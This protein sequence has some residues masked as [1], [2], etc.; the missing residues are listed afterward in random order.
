[1]TSP[2]LP[3]I[4]ILTAIVIIF[5]P[6]N[7]MGQKFE[8][9]SFRLLPND[10][11]AFINPVTDLNGEDCALIKVQASDDFAFSTPLGIVK[12]MD[13]T[14]EIWLF[15]PKG[16]KKI[17][18]KHPEWG[19][20]R[21]FAFPSKIDSHMT[22]ELKITEPD[23]P[24]PNS[25]IR[26]VI[27]TIRDTLV[28]TKVDTLVVTKPKIRIP[29]SFT[30]IATIGFGGNTNT[31]SG[32]VMLTAMRRHGGWIHIQSDFG[33]IGSTSATCDKTGNINGIT[34][35]YTGKTKHSCLQLA[36]GAI[37]RLSSKVSIFEGA[38]YG[39]TAVAWQLAESEGGGY[40]K[41]NHYSIKGVM[42]EA[43]AILTLK[44]MA[45][46]A[47]VSSIAGKQWFGSIGIGYKFG[48]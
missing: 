30:T 22:Y 27:N 24:H 47:S 23:V 20:L 39:Y 44:K 17:T 7:A 36:A 28:L 25:E 35:F 31:V 21:D 11:T 38:G 4:H 41:N 37:H 8:V 13:Q 29:F 12:R 46:S 42:F 34:P 3:Y 45:I 32:G 19:V 16:S 2:R 9:A 48:K 26:T 5:C 15:I 1:M 6:I 10:V 33:K 18:L 43:G 14:G 40:V